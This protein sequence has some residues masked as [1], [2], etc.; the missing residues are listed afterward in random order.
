M[1]NIFLKKKDLIRTNNNHI[2]PFYK[3]SK[4]AKKSLKVKIFRVY[5]YALRICPRFMLVQDLCMSQ[6]YAHPRPVH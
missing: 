1:I 2:T 3:K 6:I 4:L 5:L